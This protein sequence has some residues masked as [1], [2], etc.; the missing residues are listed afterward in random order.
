V[1]GFQNP[2]IPSYFSNIH[3]FLEIRKL[4]RR[5]R[6]RRGKG[7]HALGSILDRVKK[8]A[9][10]GSPMPSISIFSLSK[11]PG[12]G[13]SGMG[14]ARGSPFCKSGARSGRARRIVAIRLK[15]NE[16][17]YACCRWGVLWL[18][19]VV[20]VAVVAGRVP[21]F[22]AIPPTRHKDEG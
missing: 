4:K 15:T 6:K 7:Y 8:H 12:G 1:R 5:R 21:F 3:L 13:S 22:F 18:V 11:N 2:L 9:D 17:S 16:M 10:V 20:V 19:V 14:S